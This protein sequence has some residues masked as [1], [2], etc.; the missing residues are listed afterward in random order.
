MNSVKRLYSQ[1]RPKNYQIEINPNIDNK[2]FTGKVRITG[3]KV[4]PTSSRITFHQINLRITKAKVISRSKTGDNELK[5]KR[6]NYQHKSDELRLHFDTKIRSGEY[7]IELDFRGKI[8][9][10]LSGM[11]ISTNKI[12]NKTEKIITTQF[13]SHAAREVF[14][15]IDE[16]EAKAT[17][18]LSIIHKPGNSAI[19]NTPIKS[20]TKKPENEMITEFETTPIM[21]T[22]LLAFVIGNLEFKQGETKNGIVVRAYATAD[23]IDYVDF[24]LEV[25]IKCLDFYNEYFDIPYPLEK[26]DLIALPDFSSG[27]ME[28]WGCITFREH[29]MLVDP[30]RSALPNK[31]FV[32]TC[33]AHELAHQ[34]FGNLVTMKWWTDLWLNEGFATW[35]EY[36]T[37]N[38][39][40]P[41]WNV[42]TQF[43]VD[44]QQ[45]ALSSDS[46]ENTHPIEV[47]INHPDEIRTIFDNISYAKGASII[48]MLHSYVGADNFR[49]GLQDYLKKYSYKNTDTK[50][51]WNAI[52][53]ASGISIAKFMSAWT[54][55]SGY[56]IVSAEVDPDKLSLNQKRFTYLPNKADEKDLWP[57][58]I[59]SNTND[60]SLTEL[61]EKS[62]QQ[63]S[64]KFD[65]I[66]LNNNQAGFYR[67]VYGANNLSKLGN[68]VKDNKLQVADRLGLLSDLVESSKANLTDITEV[69]NFLENYQNETSYAV[70]DIIAST[71]GSI[72]AIICDE[73]LREKI[74]P[75]IKDLISTEIKRLG[76]KEK[77]DEDYF[78]TLLR[79]IILSLAASTDDEKTVEF[80]KQQFKLMVDS[81][82][83]NSV[84]PDFKGF[85]LSTVA[86]VGGRDEYNQMIKMHNDS[87]LSEEKTTLIAGITSF[88]KPELIDENLKFIK[89]DEV[90]SQ[91]IIYWVAYSFGNRLSKDKTW[92]WLKENWKWLENTLGNDLSYFRMPIF[93]ARAY[94]DNKFIKQYKEFFEPLITPSFERSYKQG[95]EIINIQSSWKEKSYDHLKAYL[96]K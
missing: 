26:C 5:I 81:P 15:C 83:T 48:N 1:F 52:S 76:I 94:S 7:L 21:S 66:K 10:E 14:P 65:V 31:Q 60:Q 28:N 44:E 29:A 92:T 32:A 74:K 35:M 86:R 19:S 91:D 34:W 6:I 20:E 37:I 73:P 53:Q 54:T 3:F 45:V 23:K 62:N 75:L 69:L 78:D 33:V 56:P 80:C 24:S 67:T 41:D 72:R 84:N 87:N 68:L 77:T 61:F 58:P 25:A 9:D 4:G 18:D 12:G 38:N 70:W 47:K 64:G 16:P 8:T 46:L 42:W 50:D 11:Y 13:E 79:P 2:D 71:L 88:K 95:L 22:Y 57:I 30:K 55:Q 39:I 36:F 63:F 27:A 93:A 17:F 90:R 82:S 43:L 49:Q 51:L 40:Y 89:T 96:S 85:I 59:L